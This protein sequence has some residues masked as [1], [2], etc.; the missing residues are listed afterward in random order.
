MSNETVGK[1]L[2]MLG[3]IIGIIAVLAAF[4]DPSL[5][6]WESHYDSIFPTLDGSYYINAFGNMRNTWNADVLVLGGLFLVGAVIFLV[7]SL[8][9]IICAIKESKGGA[10]LCSLLMIGGLVIFCYALTSNPDLINSIDFLEF[11][12]GENQNVF[13]GSISLFGTWTWRLGN[14]FFIGAVGSAIALIGSF[15]IEK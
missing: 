15:L 1:V 9:V 10:I 2:A 8:L 3:G 4:I 5:G 14:G 6:W 7:S 12:S 13:Y 11:I